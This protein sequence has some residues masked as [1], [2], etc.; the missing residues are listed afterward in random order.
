[1]KS[2][3]PAKY[4]GTRADPVETSE[5]RR[6]IPSTPR[7]TWLFLLISCAL[8][9]GPDLL[10]PEAWVHTLIYQR[11]AAAYQGILVLIGFGFGPAICRALVVR[12]LRA[13]LE[14]A[15]VD[16]AI[17]ELDGG[18]SALPRVTLAE[19]PIPFVLTAGLL[20]KQCE[21]FLSSGLVQRLSGSALRFLLARAA[22]HA[23]WPQRMGDVLPVLAFTLLLPEDLDKGSTWL[24]L[25]GALALWLGVH[26]LFELA[27][28]RQAGKAVGLEAADALREIK[29]ATRS[30]LDR[31]VPHPP[32]SWRLRAVGDG[33]DRVGVT[34]A[35]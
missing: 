6:M 8:F 31:L 26:W 16:K 21:I 10:T 5:N 34:K 2:C 11:L 20:P 13:G 29:S 17:A 27:A 1:M 30:P 25:G 19:H 28:D 3:L 23:T 32:F 35:S 15:S 12:T 9:F 18:G 4:P 33:C 7:R 24:I 22:A 14:C